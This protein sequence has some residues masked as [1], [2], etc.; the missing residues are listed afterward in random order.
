MGARVPT[1]KAVPGSSGTAFGVTYGRPPDR[2]TPPA[3]SSL[4]FNV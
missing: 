3:W 1:E 4:G 2:L